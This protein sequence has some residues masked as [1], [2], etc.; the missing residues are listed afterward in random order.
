M[1]LKKIWAGP[2]GCWAQTQGHERSTNAGE[3]SLPA[4]AHLPSLPVSAD[5]LVPKLAYL[6]R[7][8][9]TWDHIWRC[10]D[11][12]ARPGNIRAEGKKS[13]A[14]AGRGGFPACKFH[15]RA[16]APAVPTTSARRPSASISRRASA[17]SP[18]V[19]ETSPAAKRSDLWRSWRNLAVERRLPYRHMPLCG[20]S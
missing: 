19:H 4:P 17:A 11:P 18:S 12:G 5:K 14:E 13:P 1:V 7:E 2:R 3:A 6:R 16:A 10:A 9:N 8:M 15:Q 20:H